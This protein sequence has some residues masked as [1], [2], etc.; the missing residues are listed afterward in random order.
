MRIDLRPVEVARK[1]HKTPCDHQDTC[2]IVFTDNSTTPP[3]V[4]WDEEC[5]D[6]GSHWGNHR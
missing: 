6:C 5:H 3:T 4:T 2:K 1:L